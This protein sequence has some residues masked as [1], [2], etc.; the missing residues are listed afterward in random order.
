MCTADN[1]IAGIII[2]CT[3]IIGSTAAVMM[4]TIVIDEYKE[5]KSNRN[6]G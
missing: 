1:L 3:F 4:A 6:N 2:A 5:R